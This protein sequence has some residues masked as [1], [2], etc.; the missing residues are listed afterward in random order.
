MSDKIK[1][2]AFFDNYLDAHLASQRLEDA[3]IRCAVTGETAANVFSG[4]P[5]A[6]RIE[7]QVFEQDADK[8]IEILNAKPQPDEGEQPEEND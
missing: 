2:I 1:T 8:A 3:G 5:A 7:L 4:I 6:S